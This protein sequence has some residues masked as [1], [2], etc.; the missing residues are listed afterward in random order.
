ME[1]RFS[2]PSIFL[3]VRVK[4]WPVMSSSFWF[5]KVP[6]LIS[7][8]L[9]SS[10]VAT[11]IL[12]SSRSL[13]I[14]SAR[15][16]WSLWPPCDILNL[17][18]FIPLN[19]SSRRTFSSSVAGPSVQI[20]LV[21]LI[22]KRL[23]FMPRRLLQPMLKCNL[24]KSIQNALYNKSRFITSVCAKVRKVLHIFYILLTSCDFKQ[25]IKLNF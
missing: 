10:S 21:F 4:V 12:S 8:P 15:R 17:A 7:G 13:F 22:K 6:V 11:G 2:S 23:P 1:Q 3:V 5:L 25:Q 24:K 18:T 9:V 20:I 19:I 14:T 16:L